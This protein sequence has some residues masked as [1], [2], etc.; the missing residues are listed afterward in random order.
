MAT[1]RNLSTW[2]GSTGPKRHLFTLLVFSTPVRCVW[3]VE[4]RVVWGI[5]LVEWKIENYSILRG[6]CCSKW[7][8][9][10][11]EALGQPWCFQQASASALLQFREALTHTVTLPFS[12]VGQGPA[13]FLT[14]AY[15]SEPNESWIQSTVKKDI[16]FV[17]KQ[18]DV[19]LNNKNYSFS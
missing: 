10:Q 15:C 1:A 7:R 9:S 3:G 18:K 11:R 17:L 13:C 2:A 4:I 6:S 16:L 19:M 5:L 12:F 8:W 14:T